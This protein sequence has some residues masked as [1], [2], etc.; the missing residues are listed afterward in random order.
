MHVCVRGGGG[1]L[2]ELQQKPSGAPVD[3]HACSPGIWLQVATTGQHDGKSHPEALVPECPAGDSPPCHRISVWEC[4]PSQ[5]GGPQADQLLA[6]PV[7]GS[8][9]QSLASSGPCPLLEQHLVRGKNQK[10][11]GAASTACPRG[12][13]G[14]QNDSAHMAY[15]QNTDERNGMQN[16]EA[17]ENSMPHAATACQG[18]RQGSTPGHQGHRRMTGSTQMQDASHAHHLQGPQHQ[19]DVKGRGNQ[20]R[21]RGTAVARHGQ[22]LEVPTKKPAPA[23]SGTTRLRRLLGAEDFDNVSKLILLQQQQFSIQVGPSTLNCTTAAMAA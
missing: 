10:R 17:K 22:T 12:R 5:H 15:L 4:P 20:K 2:D 18:S 11:V 1:G 9:E 23:L 7:N 13:A 21:K 14:W 6:E 16:M 8:S 3:L 19:Q